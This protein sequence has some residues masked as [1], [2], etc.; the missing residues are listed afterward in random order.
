MNTTIATQATAHRAGG[1]SLF[2][3]W[4][5]LL[6]VMFDLASSPLHAHAHDLGGS[7]GVVHATEE[8][9]TH[10]DA[11]HPQA[12]H[13][14]V[15][16]HHLHS[17]DGPT[18]SHSVL[19]LMPTQQAAVM[20]PVLFAITVLSPASLAQTV[21]DP[22]RSAWRITHDLAPPGHDRHWRPIS[23]APPSSLHA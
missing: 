23:R 15:L 14:D 16:G 8:A 20:A 21:D 7:N 6:L 5:V 22:G 11:D 12:D 2:L 10:T 1:V 18:F 9:A 3:R 19:V 4:L 17:T 13:H